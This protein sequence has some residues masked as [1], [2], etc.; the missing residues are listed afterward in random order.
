MTVISCFGGL[1]RR[2]A[3]AGTA[4]AAA[5][6]TATL[7]PAGAALAAAQPAPLPVASQAAEPRH[8]ADVMTRNLYLGAS[9]DNI[10]DAL[11][12]NPSNIVSAATTTWAE[13]QAS[14]P[15]QRMAAVADEIAAGRPAVVGLQEVTKWSTYAAYNPL[16]QQ[17]VGD[18]TVEYDFLDLLLKALAERGVVYHEVSG[19]TS[20]NFTSPPI[21]VVADGTLKAVMLADRD[22]ILRRDDVDASNGHSGNFEHILQ[23]GA[24]PVAR[25]WGSADVQTRSTTFRFVNAHTEAWGSEDIRIDQVDEL[26]AAQAAITQEDGELPTVYVGDYNSAAPSGGAYQ[27]LTS[28]LGDAWAKTNRKASGFS[29]C[30]APLLNN[31]TSDLDQRIDLVLTTKDVTATRSYLTGTSPVDLPGDTWWASDHAGVVARLVIH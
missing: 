16:T 20:D 17:P 10:I 30:Q 29:C 26:F 22:V 12:E 5:A 18:P 19:A 8:T 2:L 15:E 11:T 7:A 1:R 31:T 14:D 4:A 9:L 21:P 6:L 24:L 3:I 25:G 28:Q 27:E 13:V 23:L